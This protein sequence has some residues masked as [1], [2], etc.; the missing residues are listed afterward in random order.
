MKKKKLN[1][2]ISIIMLSSSLLSSLFLL[3]KSVE[4]LNLVTSNLERFV[5]VLEDSLKLALNKSYTP[6]VS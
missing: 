1:K 2:I 4:V 3:S 5:K 6:K